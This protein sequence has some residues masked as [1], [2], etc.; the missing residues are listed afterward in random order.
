MTR[1]SDT[2]TGQR[3]RVV[4]KWVTVKKTIQETNEGGDNSR[5][6]KERPALSGRKEIEP[7][8]ADNQYHILQRSVPGVF[9]KPI[10]FLRGLNL[11]LDRW[12]GPGKIDPPPR[13]LKSEMKQWIMN[14]YFQCLM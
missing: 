2:Q 8:W 13:Q 10:E 7:V 9:V 1:W 12:K 11:L 3:Q 4:K 5:V 6:A 14:F